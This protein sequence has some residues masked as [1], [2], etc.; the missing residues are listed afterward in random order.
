MSILLGF[1]VLRVEGV[2]RETPTIKTLFF[3]DESIAKSA[4][5]GQFL[6]VWVPGVDEVPMSLSFIGPEGRIG[7]TV[8]KV[9]EATEAL[10]KCEPGSLIGIR[11]PLGRGFTLTSG[12]ALVVGG[13][14]GVAALAPLIEELASSNTSPLT[15]IIGAR[16]GRE[17][18]FRDRFA[19]VL[20]GSRHSLMVATDDGSVGFKGRASA[21]AAKVLAKGGCDQV[22]ACGP[23]P[24]LKDLLNASIRYGVLAQMSLERVIKCGVGLCGACAIDGYRVCKDGPVFDSQTLQRLKDFGR[25]ARDATGRPVS[26]TRWRV[27]KNLI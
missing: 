5:P 8:A 11:G 24:M 18:L 25:T 4:V 19:K 21:L 23:E 6:M 2:K 7:I 14:V 22:Y 1:K 26:V 27:M 13:G 10:H 12:R 9:G 20:K 15:V 17:L 3:T 16:T